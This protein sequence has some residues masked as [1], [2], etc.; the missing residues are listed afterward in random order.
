MGELRERMRL[1]CAP[2]NFATLERARDTLHRAT[3]STRDVLARCSMGLCATRQ[4][5]PRA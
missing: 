5:R 2:D 1:Y 4:A 3:M